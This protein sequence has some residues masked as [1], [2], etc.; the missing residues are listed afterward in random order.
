MGMTAPFVE[1]YTLVSAV[2]TNSAQ[3]GLFRPQDSQQG[4]KFLAA[5][6]AAVQVSLHRWQQIFRIDAA[7]NQFGQT[8]DLLAAG[9]T[10]HAIAPRLVQ[11]HHLFE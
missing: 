3:A 6:T 2:S 4:F 11:G 1:V 10:V 5:V 8:I 7:C 9:L